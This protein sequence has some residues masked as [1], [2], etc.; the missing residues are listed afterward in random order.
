MK[1][2]FKVTDVKREKK[3]GVAAE[4]L[5]ELIQKSCKKLGF[6]VGFAECKLFV[7]EDGT[8]VD[9]DDYLDTLPSQTLFILLKNKETMV[10]DFDYYYNV[11]RSSGKDYIETGVAAKEFLSTNIKEKFRVFQKYVAAANDARTM[12]SERSQDPGWFEGLDPS[13]K[14]K[15][16]TMSKRV[17]ERMKGYYYKTKTALQSSELY[18]NSKRGRGKKLI[19]QFLDDL[20]KLLES[21][22]YNET[23]FNRK[24]EKDARLCNENGLFQC[25]GLW[26]NNTCA[27]EG[28]HIINPYRSREERIIF[29]TWNLDHKIELSRSIIPKILEAIQWLYNENIKCISCDS[30]FKN[31]SIETDRYYLQIFTR[32]NLKLVHIVC[33][34]KG[35][36][37]IQSDIYTMC[38]NCYGNTSI[39]YIK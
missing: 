17:K 6:N 20:R 21:N 7:A 25:G 8:R 18:I 35:K 4:N 34:F 22:K 11:I 39:E 12:L 3:I 2:G 30:N 16:Q 32:Y 14:T 5:N 9:D 31:G 15:E 19:D 1:K 28:E 33:H 13:E 36:H 10:T 38:K 23:Y 24:A 26:N 29:Q 37:S 27:Y